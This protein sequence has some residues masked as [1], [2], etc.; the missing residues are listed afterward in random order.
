MDGA[1]IADAATGQDRAPEERNIGLVFQDSALFPHLTVAENVAFGL[2]ALAPDKRRGRIEEMLA[3]VAMADFAGAYPHALS[4]GQQQRIALARA[5]APLPKVMLLDEP[6]S[7]LDAR[8]RA[9]I[10]D[11]TRHLLKRSGIASLLVTHDPEEAMFMADR[12]YV[13]KAGRVVQQGTPEALYRHPVDAFVAGFLQPVNRLKARVRGG[14]VETPFGP[15]A[16]PGQ[17]EGAPVDILIRPETIRLV[18]AGQG[19]PG[20]IR[21]LRFVG[22][23]WL[24]RIACPDGEGGEIPLDL[25]LDGTERPPIDTR[26]DFAIDPSAVLIFP[27]DSS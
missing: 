11:E 19:Y 20:R 18:P 1:I 17:A 2:G 10:R 24:A 14:K 9:Q 16:A 4:G 21:E 5:L 27:G 7:G 25:R 15:V 12:L 3:Q 23:A 22:L 8:L 26:L 6:F 13:M